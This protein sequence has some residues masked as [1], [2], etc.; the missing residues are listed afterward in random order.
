MTTGIST[1]MMT[2]GRKT[3]TNQ[4]YRDTTAKWLGKI[5]SATHEIERLYFSTQNAAELEHL[6]VVPKNRLA[7]YVA[8]LCSVRLD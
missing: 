2:T 8:G 4:E 6:L 1:M 7:R 3:M 5:M